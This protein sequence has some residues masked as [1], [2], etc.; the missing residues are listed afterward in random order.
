MGLLFQT[1]VE[2]NELDDRIKIKEETLILKTYGLPMVFWGYLAALFVVLFFMILAIKDPLI[3]VLT[4]EDTINKVIGI[5]L[6]GLLTFGPLTLLGFYF[7]EKVI[8]K[9]KD[10]LVIIHKTFFLPLIKKSYQIDP[11]SIEIEHFLD[12][13]NMA[14]LDKKQGM[15]GF[16]NRGYFK[17]MAT[18]EGKKILIDR[19]SR[20]GEM[21]KLKEL[22]E[23]Y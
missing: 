10:Q 14:A 8:K 22:L 4:G 3:K 15:A 9:K 19:N 1:P 17:L 11:G 16:E 13:P 18:S 2:L 7:Y 20:R 5:L 12:S 6:T 23:K 21:R